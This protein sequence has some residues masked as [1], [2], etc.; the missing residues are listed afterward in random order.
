MRT[1]VSVVVPVYNP[2]PAIEACIASL[3]GQSIP[4]DRLELIFVDDGSTD[5]TP[6]RLDELAKMHANVR[7]I[8]IPASGAPGR[9]RNVGLA[10]ARGEYIHFVDADDALAPRALEWLTAMADE[11]DSDVVIGKYASATLDRSQA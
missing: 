7:I 6:R 8:R 1:K 11:Y 3:I 2:G 9:P 4:A 10:Q 5:G